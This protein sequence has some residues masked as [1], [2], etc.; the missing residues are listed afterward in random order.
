MELDICL[1]EVA[2]PRL[3]KE[4]DAG[5]SREE[6]PWCRTEGMEYYACKKENEDSN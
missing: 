6:G 5:E 4:P 1:V 2:V 3:P